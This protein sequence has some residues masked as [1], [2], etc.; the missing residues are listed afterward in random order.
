M[1]VHKIQDRNPRRFQASN[2]DSIESLSNFHAGLGP[3]L[4][5]A[6]TGAPCPAAVTGPGEYTIYLAQPPH[7][8]FIH[9]ASPSVADQ[10]VFAH[11]VMAPAAS[12][13]EGV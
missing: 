11:T 10:A 13:E 4:E 1:H 2:F 7:L 6:R 9:P 8:V 12:W 3:A 5:P